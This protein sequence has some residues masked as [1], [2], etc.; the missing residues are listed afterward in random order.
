MRGE[1]SFPDSTPKVML[2]SSNNKELTQRE[3][4]I[5]REIVKGLS[6]KQIAE[7]CGIA[8]DT[9]NWHV[10][11]LLAKTGLVNRTMLAIS[12]V[13]GNLFI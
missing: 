10:K 3:N 7:K 4:I 1:A 12:A 5:L 9:V 8:E 6:N 2:G 13:R 11:N